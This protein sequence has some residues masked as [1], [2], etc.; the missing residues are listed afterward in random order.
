MKRCS[1]IEYEDEVIVEFYDQKT[2]V[3]SQYIFDSWDEAIEALKNIS[4]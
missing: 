3:L 4:I 1:I 2:K